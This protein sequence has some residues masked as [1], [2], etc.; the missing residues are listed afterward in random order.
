MGA[1]TAVATLR[2]GAAPRRPLKPS[3][4]P[5]A[6]AVGARANWAQVF[7][8]RPALWALPLY[9]GGPDGDGVSWPLNPRVVAGLP[10]CPRPPPDV[11]VVRARWGRVLWAPMWAAL[12]WEHWFCCGGI[13]VGLARQVLR[14]FF[15]VRSNRG[16]PY[17]PREHRT[18]SRGSAYSPAR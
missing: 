12:Q 1:R 13:S 17:V 3:A 16:Y 8:R 7:G 2:I 14:L 6:E 4:P 15:L 9:G 10:T 11:G 5:A 18:S